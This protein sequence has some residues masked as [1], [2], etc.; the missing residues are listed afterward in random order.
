MS[1]RKSGAF[2]EEFRRERCGWWRAA[3][4]R[5]RRSPAN[6]ASVT[7]RYAAGDATRVRRGPAAGPAGA[8]TRG[9]G[10]VPSLGEEVRRLR[11]ENSRLLEER[12]ILKKATAFFAR[13]A[14]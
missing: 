12:E 11:R 8:V 1:R 10:V 14:R 5:S 2:S 9:P 7:R 13:D 4:S 3:T 6:S